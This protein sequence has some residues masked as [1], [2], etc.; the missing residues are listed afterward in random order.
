MVILH[1]VGPSCGPLPG[2][3]HAD[4]VG[5][6]YDGDDGGEELGPHAGV[7]VAAVHVAQDQRGQH[8]REDV[9]RGDH[10]RTTA[11]R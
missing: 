7:A 9:C 10:L 4:V 11:P 3:A 8:Q 5:E 6:R 2:D 1:A